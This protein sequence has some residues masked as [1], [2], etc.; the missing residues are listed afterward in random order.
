MVET[1]SPLRVQKLR[2]RLASAHRT[3]FGDD[4]EFMAQAS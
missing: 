1:V 2:E 4:A 3:L